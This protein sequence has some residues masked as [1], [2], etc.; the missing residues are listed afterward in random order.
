[1]LSFLFFYTLNKTALEETGCSSN[2]QFY[3]QVTSFLIYLLF[4]NTVSQVTLGAL[5]KNS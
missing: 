3:T 1:M 4:L 2:L 5:K